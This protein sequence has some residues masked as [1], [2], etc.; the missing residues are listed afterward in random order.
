MLITGPGF[1]KCSDWDAFGQRMSCE[2]G[3]LKWLVCFS[4]AAKGR[5]GG[6]PPRNQEG[7]RELHS[8]ITGGEVI[9]RTEAE[10]F[11]R[12]VSCRHSGTSQE[13]NVGRQIT[14]GLN[15]GKAWKVKYEMTD[16]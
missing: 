12:T 6:D 15:Q 10:N 16:C 1:P 7:L 9:G 8:E 3:F 5:S 11:S 14:E 4:T 13:R 2:L